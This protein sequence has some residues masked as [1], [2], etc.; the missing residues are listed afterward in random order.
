MQQKEMAAHLNAKDLQSGIRFERDD[1]D[2]LV[3]RLQESHQS[4]STRR[5]G[6]LKET[7]HVRCSLT[8]T[9]HFRHPKCCGMTSNNFRLMI[10]I[11]HPLQIKLK[12]NQFIRTKRYG[13]LSM[14]SSS[15][16][17]CLS[18]RYFPLVDTAIA[19]NMSDPMSLLRYSR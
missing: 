4:P 11:Q 2:R 8:A 16:N 14:I 3:L 17:D 1:S 5:S 19:Q 12:I 7:Y 18:L 10:L 6:K 9:R 13:N 15:R